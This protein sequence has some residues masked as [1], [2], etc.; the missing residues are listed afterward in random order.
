MYISAPKK[1]KKRPGLVYKMAGKR[2]E[3]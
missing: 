1:R 3:Y 2:K